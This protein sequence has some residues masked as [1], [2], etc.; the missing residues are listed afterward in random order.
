MYIHTWTHQSG[1]G[2]TTV[3]PNDNCNVT[4]PSPLVRSLSPPTSSP[5]LSPSPSQ[6]GTFTVSVTVA[7]GSGDAGLEAYVVRVQ[8]TLGNETFF[9]LVSSVGHELVVNLLLTKENC[10]L[11]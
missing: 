6:D 10:T 1:N 9:A 5:T 2:G 7:G 4:L 8:D 3:C 11:I